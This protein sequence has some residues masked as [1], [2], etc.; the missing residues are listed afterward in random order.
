MKIIW[1]AKGEEKSVECKSKNPEKQQKWAIKFL[2]LL[3]EASG[4]EGKIV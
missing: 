2:A 3:K 4:I 1:T